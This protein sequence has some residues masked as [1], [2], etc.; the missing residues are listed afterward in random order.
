MVKKIERFAKRFDITSGRPSTD[1]FYY[2]N[3]SDQTSNGTCRLQHRNDH[4]QKAT[5]KKQYAD[6]TFS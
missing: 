5:E 6:A 3:A 4:D 1:T 2:P